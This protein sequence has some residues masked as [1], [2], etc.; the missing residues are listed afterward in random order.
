MKHNTQQIAETDWCEDHKW[1]VNQMVD[2]MLFSIKNVREDS[3]HYVDQ[4]NMP[5]IAEYINILYQMMHH[6]IQAKLKDSTGVKRKEV[7]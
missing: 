5:D 1:T 3:E 7:K 4:L 6:L 2:D